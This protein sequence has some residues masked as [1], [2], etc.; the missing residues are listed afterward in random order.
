MFCGLGFVPLRRSPFAIAYEIDGL[1]SDLLM[2]FSQ[3]CRGNCGHFGISTIRLTR[4]PAFSLFGLHTAIAACDAVATYGSCYA[5]LCLNKNNGIDREACMQP[6]CGCCCSFS[7]H[8]AAAPF[9][10]CIVYEQSILRSEK[11]SP[12]SSSFRKGLN[13]HVNSS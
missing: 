5:A 11:L 10:L 13:N 9:A 8:L 1:R 12:S 6:A 7:S 2:T 4:T 3:C